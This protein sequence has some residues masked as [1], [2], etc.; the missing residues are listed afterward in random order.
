MKFLGIDIPFTKTAPKNNPAPNNPAPNN[1]VESPAGT[2]L[3]PP[4]SRDITK[5]LTGDLDYDPI[6]EQVNSGDLAILGRDSWDILGDDTK[7]D[8][9]LGEELLKRKLDLWSGLE[10]Q[11]LNPDRFLR[12][13]RKTLIFYD[14]MMLD[15]RI[16][17]ITDLK[18]RSILSVPYTFNPASDR[19][20]DKTICEDV[21]YQLENLKLG[22]YNISLYDILD[23]FL[24]APYY[25]FKCAEKVYRLASRTH[26]TSYVRLCSIKHRHSIFFDFL[27]DDY[28]NLQGVWVGRFYGSQLIVKDDFFRKKFMVFTYPYAVDGN[29]YGHSELQEIYPQYR[30]KIKLFN[31]RNEKLEGF[32]KPIPIATFASA[33]M[34][35]GERSDLESQLKYFQNNKYFT[36]PGT[37]NQAG[38]IMGKIKLEFREAT[39]TSPGGDD[40][41]QALDQ[42]DTQIARK[43]LV[44]DK[45]GMS[46][47]DGGSYALGE[48]QHNLYLDGIAH[49][50]RKLENLINN[51]IREMVDFNYQVTEY[52]TFKF[53][54]MSEKLIADDVQKLVQA[55]VV[56]PREKWLRG[57]IG[58]PSITVT[59]QE[60]LDEKSLTK[61]QA[62]IPP[63]DPVLP[64]ET[65]PT[66]P[67]TPGQAK[68]PAHFKSKTPPIKFKQIQK[69][70]NDNEDEFIIALKAVYADCSD[71][72]IKQVKN[73]KIVEDK[74]L[75]AI[76]TLKINK[77]DLKA[78]VQGYL[79]K[80]YIMG[81]A[82]AIEEVRPRFKALD[83]PVQFKAELKDQ[84]SID[85]YLDWLNKDYIDKYLAE[86]KE[87][88]DLTKDDIAYLSDLKQQGFFITGDIETDMVRD[89]YEALVEGFRSGDSADNI[90]AK[91][92]ES[93]SEDMESRAT[94]IA[95]TNEST[96]YNSGR[97]NFFNQEG[98]QDNIEAY[99]YSAII[100][101]ATTQ[102]CEEHN[103]QIIL[104]TDPDFGR[105]NPPNHFNCRSMLIPI[106][107]GDTDLKGGPYEGW[108]DDGADWNK[109]TPK[110][111]RFPSEGFGRPAG[112]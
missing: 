98:I 15:D 29:I 106:F 35:S 65:A 44:P 87:W 89:V 37:R 74:N 45:M 112:F 24:D 2:D 56:D 30:A 60:E 75:E 83:I 1:P 5:P 57:F 72:L 59:E 88:G 38:E 110:D 16:K 13:H 31:F 92:K 70:L 62:A 97:Q 68:S 85:D 53:D 40:Y 71:A 96:A 28:K 46:D 20:Q 111:Q 86:Y 8:E 32:G 41:T 73:K 91:I 61:K 109:G 104:K 99:E 36:I 18:K 107:T 81:K 94:T 90:I 33:E 51:L 3:L 82:E 4:G 77:T 80:L 58:V 48:T 10:L 42:I 25:G 79:V 69:E 54:E 67:G 64:G 100:D 55:G 17:S 93:L 22:E 12:E 102:F 11:F 39:R 7:T 19:D 47:S 78:L 26:G 6:R 84:V 76:N 49:D 66:V 52:P 43:L 101:N 23:N 9:D 27:Y 103:G 95:R 21:Q 50:Q 63:G 105:I 108:Q 34:S 14:T